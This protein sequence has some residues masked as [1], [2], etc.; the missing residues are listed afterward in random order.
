[1]PGMTVAADISGSLDVKNLV[2]GV[3]EKGVALSNLMSMIKTTVQVPRLD[4]T[5]PVLTQ[6]AVTRD[7][8]ELQETDIEGGSFT[9]VTFA[10]KKDRVKLAISDEAEYRSMAGNPLDIQVQG[11]GVKLAAELD[12]KIVKALET[13]EQ[14]SACAGAAT[15]NTASNSP[16]VELGTAVAAIRPYKADFVIMT[17]HVWS[18]YLLSD[19]VKNA[20]TGNPSGTAGAIAKVPGLDL[21]IF[22]DSNLTENTFMV[23]AS[24]GMPAVLGQGPVKV[25]KWDSS[26][27]GA[28][29]YQMDVYRQVKA[30]IFLNDSSLNM[31]AY[32]VTAITT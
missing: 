1:M 8:D 19:F 21:N 16:L 32:A 24:E 9:N 12:Y 23:G 10:L 17:P 27:N 18:H 2:M 30:P 14:T 22:I 7:V 25:R 28:T 4:A 15:W 3:L 5:I 11:A 29:I 26:H 6:G 13:S 31:A 20:G